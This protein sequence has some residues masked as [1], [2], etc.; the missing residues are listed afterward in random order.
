M[1][2]AAGRDFCSTKGDH[3][4]MT[5]GF[6]NLPWFVWAALSLVTAGVFALFVPGRDR[7]KAVSGA[8][9][10]IARWF[11]SLVWALLGLSF[12]V[13]GLDSAGSAGLADLLAAAGDC[14]TPYS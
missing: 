10:V 3:G 13:R 8:R 1:I 9:F 5:P 11:H 7:I 6:L 14:A 12:V 2:I 4:T